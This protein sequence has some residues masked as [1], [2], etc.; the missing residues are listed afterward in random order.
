MKEESIDQNDS[1]TFLK[2]ILN[3]KKDKQLDLVTYLSKNVNENYGST[4]SFFKKITDDLKNKGLLSNDEYK[5]ILKPS[6]IINKSEIS[7]ALSSI[8]REME[9]A[10][11]E[12]ENLFILYYLRFRL[13]LVAI[14]AN[15]ISSSK[16]PLNPPIV[17]LSKNFLGI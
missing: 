3:D 5:V 10:A 4:K 11:D 16:S 8:N 9:E 17:L 2:E 13:F 7:K 14:V 12:F 15:F 6:R 1:I